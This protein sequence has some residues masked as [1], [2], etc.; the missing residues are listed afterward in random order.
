MPEAQR[1]DYARQVY[2]TRQ[3]VRDRDAA[4]QKQRR[5]EARARLWDKGCRTVKKLLHIST[6]P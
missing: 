3:W 2:H 4:A 1:A 6:Q 5:A